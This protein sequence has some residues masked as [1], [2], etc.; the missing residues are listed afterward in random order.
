MNDSKLL[1]PD[2]W[3]GTNLDDLMAALD[4][5]FDI[6]TKNSRGRTVLH[7]VIARE[8]QCAL[9][10]LL[11]FGARVDTQDDY[12]ESPLHLAV[13]LKN[14]RIVPLLL[15][16]NAD[17]HARDFGGATPLFYA[18][19]GSQNEVHT[20]IVNALLKSGANPNARDSSGAN[21]FLYA[22][23]LGNLFV[24]ELLLTHGADAQIAD[25]KGRSL[26][27]YSA[28]ETFVAAEELGDRL[29]LLKQAVESAA[30]DLFLSDSA[31]HEGRTPL[32][33]TVAAG[34]RSLLRWLLDRGADLSGG[35][36]FGGKGL[37]PLHFA[38]LSDWY[39]G[40][41]AEDIIAELLERGAN[42]NIRDLNQRTPLHLA[43]AFGKTTD[44]GLQLLLDQGADIHAVDDYGMMPLDYA[45]FNGYFDDLMESLQDTQTDAETTDLSG[46]GLGDRPDTATI[47]TALVSAVKD[48]LLPHS[49]PTQYV[50]GAARKKHHDEELSAAASE[51]YYSAMAEI[52]AEQGLTLEE[53]LD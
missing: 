13:A 32:H 7:E 19:R 6:E 27:H 49:D 9:V 45:A 1:D 30:E 3:S 18:M 48:V 42:V 4:G 23:E 12:G 34:N 16:H 38:F 14:Q 29:P 51:E 33:Y 2:F 31:D 15:S 52:A 39:L 44:E 8:D 35:S 10:R 28:L 17:V 11:G 50:P 22:I 47:Y 20:D 37:S 46:Q 36:M 43:M 40:D 21:P 5:G 24:A 26:L 53:L 41:S 25:A